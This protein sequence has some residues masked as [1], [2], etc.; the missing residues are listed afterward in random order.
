VVVIDRIMGFA[1]VLDV[2]NKQVG[3]VHSEKKGS[4]DDG[5]L[6]SDVVGRRETRVI[7]IQT[8]TDVCVMITLVH[9]PLIGL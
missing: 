8:L 3:R 6:R 9:G 7:T 5:K 4:V 1:R 2:Q